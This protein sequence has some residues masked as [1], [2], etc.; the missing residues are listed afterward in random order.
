MSDRIVR[1]IH[2]EHNLVLVAC[3][4]TEAAREG[5][6]RHGLARSSAALLGQTLTGGLLI[7]A[8]QKSE[9]TRINI[10]VECDGPAGGVFVDA[11]PAGQ[12]RGFVRNRSVAFPPEPRFLAAPLLGATGYISVLRDVAGELYRG[13][14]NIGEGDLSLN[15][16]TYFAT[17]EQTA[18]TLQ[19]EALADGPEELG[20]VGGLLIQR[21]PGGDEAALDAVRAR[22]RAGAIEHAV[23]GG[24]RT[25]HALIDAVVGEDGAVDLL[26]DQ[27]ATYFCAC[28]RER[29][30]RALMVLPNIDL[31]EMITQ[32]GKASVDCDFCG[33][34][35]E[36]SEEELRRVLDAVDQRDAAQAEASHRPGGSSL[37]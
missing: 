31:V 15:L 3:V 27:D 24:A 8:L 21:L 32:E 35:Y 36:V 13:T 1:A 25:A 30:F 9:Q 7:A 20:W 23:Q 16:E 17:S 19:L 28:S 12:V 6:R 26:A 11:T 22:L 18:T 33:A 4:A 5:R 34:H 29:V 2:T 14:V 10:Q 37:N